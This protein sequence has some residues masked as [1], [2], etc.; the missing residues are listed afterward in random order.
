MLK[1]LSLVIILVT[2]FHLA[3][4]CQTP[5]FDIL[6]G[7]EKIST[8]CVGVTITLRNTSADTTTHTYH[9]NING[10]EMTT[11]STIFIF[12]KEGTYSIR[13]TD[14]NSNLS[15]TQNFIVNPLPSVSFNT[16]Q[17]NICAG[18]AVNFTSTSTS[19]VAIQSYY[20]NFDDE[21]TI[22]NTP[23]TTY[24]FNKAGNKKVYLFVKDANGC[25]SP[26]SNATT[27]TVN[28][29]NNAS[30]TTTNGLFYS[31]DNTIS[32]V[33]TSTDAGSSYN[34]N[35]GDG[36][37]FNGTASPTHTYDKPGQYIV[38]LTSNTS[39]STQCASKFSHTV[40]VGKPKLKITTVDNICTNTT[41]NI[42]VA[43]TSGNFNFKPSDYSWQTTNGNFVS[44]NTALYY[45]VAGTY[46]LTAVNKNGCPAPVSKQITVNQTP[47]LQLSFSPNGSICKIVPITFTAK[48]DNN[49]TLNW[50]LGDGSSRTTTNQDTIVYTYGKAG[51][52]NASVE[53]TNNEG[54]SI[55]SSI[56]NIVLNDNCTDNGTDSSL[57]PVFRFYSACDNKYL[58][59]FEVRSNK[60]PLASI[61][62]DEQTYAFENGKVT[63]QLPFKG[64][65][66]TYNVLVK[67]A[68]GTYDVAREITIMD[69]SANFSM[70]DNDN[71]TRY[72]AQNNYI[73]SASGYVNNANISKYV[74]TIKDIQK[75]SLIYQI[76]GSNLNTINYF[77]PYASTYSVSLAIFD[78]RDNPCESDTSQLVTVYGPSG[79]FKSLSDSVFCT[80]NASI[81]LQNLSSINTSTYQSMTWDFGDGTTR[82]YTDGNIPDTIMHN[83]KYIGTANVTTYNVNLKITDIDGCTS[84]LTLGN[85]YKLY[86]AQLSVAP[87]DSIYCS[88]RTITIINKSNIADLKPNGFQWQVGNTTQN[89]NLNQSFSEPVSITDFP[90][91]YDVKVSA[92]Y[93]QGITCTK[94]TT[95][96][97]LVKF[98]KPKAAFTI[99]DSDQLNICPPYI[100]HL[101]NDAS[102]YQ[103]L[104]WTLSDSIY[105]SS[106]KDTILY[107]IERPNNYS[108]KLKVNGYDHC[109][110]S[111]LYAFVSK[112]PKATL[113]NDNYKSCV[114]LITTLRLHST[115]PIENYLWNFGDS[116]TLSSPTATTATHQYTQSGIYTP[117]ITIIGTVE[118]GH[119]FNNLEVTTPI[120]V[121][122][123]INLQ[124]QT[125]YSYCLSDSAHGGIK[126]SVASNTTNNFTWSTDP[127]NMNTITTDR[128][129]NFIVAKPTAA[130]TV[131][132]VLSRSQNSCPDETANIT[133]D[134]HE[135]PIVTFSEHNLTL[136]AGTTF[137]PNP[138][139]HST[140]STLKYLWTPTSGMNNQYLLNPQI[141]VDNDITYQLKVTNTFGCSGTDSLHIKTLC[142]ASKIFIPSGFTPNDD[143][144]NDVFYVK[145]YGIK[146]VNHFIVVDRWGKTIFERNNIN[147]ND[148]SQGWN[149]TVNATQAAPGTYVYFA[150]VTCSEG[151]RFQL[152]GTVVLIR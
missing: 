77:M 58:V 120:Q 20:W 90:T 150:E 2:L 6:V 124:Y 100:L 128:F 149:G 45:T 19:Q 52:Y 8:G 84:N 145:G 34:W 97:G 18:N 5:S 75:D 134:T 46:T 54:C 62:I 151:N 108:I 146:I 74:W 17:T 112:G 114:P 117:S 147:A 104:Q 103:S 22:S 81:V 29:A 48:T 127:A 10:Y 79:N 50:Q 122:E 14:D 21:A 129:Q 138:S 121:D 41:F 59:T 63:V 68:D 95:Y 143:G 142:S 82:R 72:C 94:D 118:D 101:H 140:Y 36:N 44:D 7:N 131:Y 26:T 30:F 88:T 106:L 4:K 107:Y 35:F 28:G 86:N 92:T 135:S 133:V 110:D 37:V 119:C 12:L 13:L 42:N 53:A 16:S 61:T 64:K 96:P 1:K 3:P 33:N 113:T 141:I 91:Y 99:L 69:E 39:S 43:D 152:K 123:K 126:L 87:S 57:N 15:Y 40:Y 102:G 9:W 11:T 60:K 73:F 23:T 66:A 51:T 65:G 83:Y 93:G 116:T 148:V 85:K 47:D 32:L 139:V 76:S 89:L 78:K 70:K 115:D 67:Y 132:T 144:K 55:V 25:Y 130:T 24:V 31:C 80:P 71:S 109:Y 105:N 27:I 137:N 38:V 49:I 111:T 98:I 125:P 56:Q 136:P